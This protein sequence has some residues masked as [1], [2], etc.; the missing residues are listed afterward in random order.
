MSQET[1]VVDKHPNVKALELLNQYDVE[2]F[3]V[4]ELSYGQIKLQ[5]HCTRKSVDKYMKL[6]FVFE[7]TENWLHGTKDGARIV[8]TYTT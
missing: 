2:D 8:L 7:V 3:Y 5:G 6:G 1:T 4:C